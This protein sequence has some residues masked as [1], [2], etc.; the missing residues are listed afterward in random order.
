M[1]PLDSIHKQ[2][3]EYITAYEHTRGLDKPEKIPFQKG[4]ESQTQSTL[5]S[6]D[7]LFHDSASGLPQ[8]LPYFLKSRWIE[9]K[10][11]HYIQGG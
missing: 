5:R 7:K 4:G 10:T 3:N 6:I 8:D 1:H 11:G 2:Y 9:G